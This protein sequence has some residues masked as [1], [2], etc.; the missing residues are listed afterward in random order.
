LVQETLLKAWRSRQRYTPD[1]NLDAWLFTILRNTFYSAHRKH[2]REVE[3]ADDAYAATLSVAP[4]Q[5]DRLALQDMQTALAKLPADMREALLLVTLNELT[6]DDAAAV[7]GCKVGTIK[8]R[9]SRAR[10]RLA[11]LLGYASGDDGS[12][13][14]SHIVVSSGKLA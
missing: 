3:D 12:D 11:H 10:E 14:L 9:V 2:A 5:G 8:S 1:T 7:A 4:V 13:W 6:Y